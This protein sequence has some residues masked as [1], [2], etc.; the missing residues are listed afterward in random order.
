[1][2]LP[3]ALAIQLQLLAGMWMVQLFPA[4]VLGV[5]TRFFNGWGLLAGWAAGMFAATSM[6]LS[7]QLKSSVFPLH[8]CGHIYPMYAAIPALVMNLLVS[9]AGTLLA[10]ALQAPQNPPMP[11]AD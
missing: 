3:N 7:L 5:F 2:W 10:R 9:I 4:V 11:E 6:A 8:L 1:L